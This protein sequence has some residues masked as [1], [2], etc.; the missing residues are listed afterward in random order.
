MKAR[1]VGLAVVAAGAATAA[2]FA[3]PAPFPRSERQSERNTVTLR[4]LQG[5]WKVVSFDA[6]G[7]D[8]APR[9]VRWFQGVRVEA[10]SFR[11]LVDGREHTRFRVAVDGRCRPAEI[12]FLH[13][14]NNGIE[15]DR[16]YMVGIVGRQGARVR[17]AYF[18]TAPE[19]RAF[20]FESVPPRWW[21]LVLER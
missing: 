19:N 2:A 15:H 14:P 17:I 7:E 11:Y 6:I 20:S 1:L 3:A 13:E 12:D 9:D 8:G 18:W 21:I 4:S 10:D 16:P 5:D